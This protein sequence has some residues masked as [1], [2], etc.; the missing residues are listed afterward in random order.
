MIS[1]QEAISSINI[2]LYF[3]LSSNVLFTQR[4][5][6][7]ESFATNIRFARANLLWMNKMMMIT[8]III[9]IKEEDDVQIGEALRGEEGAR[10]RDSL[11]CS[12]CPLRLTSDGTDKLAHALSFQTPNLDPNQTQTSCCPLFLADP[13]VRWMD[14]GLIVV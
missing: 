12:L 8:S 4:R 1:T 9:I 7:S 2:K 14:G 13:T 6:F 3:F 11:L 10:L 5:S